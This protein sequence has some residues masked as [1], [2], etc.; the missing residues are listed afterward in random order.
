MAENRQDNYSGRKVL[1]AEIVD[2]GSGISRPDSVYQ[3]G[4]SGN[5]AI[6]IRSTGL[7]GTGGCAAGIITLGI[8]LIC[9]SQYGLLAAI[10]FYVFYLLGGLIGFF[11]LVS[12]TL[13]LG[14][15]APR[16]ASLWVWRICD[17][18]ISYFLAAYLAGAFNN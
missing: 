13:K 12:K 10:G 8:A 18:L 2:S 5:G 11:F 17:W 15:L 3:R 16:S 7:V 4:P 14:L 9:L 6:F 1:D